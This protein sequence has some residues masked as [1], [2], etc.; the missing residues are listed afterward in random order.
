MRT[1]VPAVLIVSS[2]HRPLTEVSRLTT[3]YTWLL[4]SVRDCTESLIAGAATSHMVNS[5]RRALSDPSGINAAV[6]FTVVIPGLYAQ[7]WSSLTELRKRLGGNWVLAWQSIVEAEEE[8]GKDELP[9]RIGKLP[10]GPGGKVLPVVRERSGLRA[11]V[12]EALR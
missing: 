4:P 1:S 9:E 7:Y 5:T 10:P 2:G 8:R 6:L 3:L 11:I 12:V